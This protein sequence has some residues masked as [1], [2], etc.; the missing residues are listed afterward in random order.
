MPLPRRGDSVIAAPIMRMSEVPPLREGG[1]GRLPFLCM[2]C[3]GVHARQGFN[4][5]PLP[6]TGHLG[7]VDLLFT[8]ASPF[9]S[10]GGVILA[11]R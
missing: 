4:I 7:R 6:A 2:P 3:M 11:S 9:P 5:Q 8:V 1:R 10:Q